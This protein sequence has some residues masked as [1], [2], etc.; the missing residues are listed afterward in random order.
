MK[1]ISDQEFSTLRESI[2]QGQGANIFLY[3]EGCAERGIA[4]EA[5]A[6]AT[7]MIDSGRAKDG[8]LIMATACTLLTKST[9]RDYFGDYIHHANRYIELA[10]NESSERDIN[11]M[12]DM[13]CEIADAVYERDP[14]AAIPLFERAATSGSVWA[15][16]VLSELYMTGDGVEPDPVKAAYWYMESLKP[17][18]LDV[19]MGRITFDFVD[20]DHN[21]MIETPLLLD[22]LEMADSE[23]QAQILE[24]AGYTADRA[25][26]IIDAITRRGVHR[27]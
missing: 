21:G 26:Q 25:A 11:K 6:H 19:Y 5:I 23:A 8:H 20:H 13:M 14:G 2:Q 24:L 22:L 17:G 9:G 18:L 12:V 7:K 16:L 27:G 3:I 4:D 1:I 15:R 10:A